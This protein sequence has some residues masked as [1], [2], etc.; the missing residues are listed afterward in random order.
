MVLYFVLDIVL[1]QN[2][3]SR[4]GPGGAL[5]D[6]GCASKSLRH[7]GIASTKNQAGHEDEVKFLR[8]Q[9]EQLY[10]ARVALQEKEN[11]LLRGLQGCEH[12]ATG[13]MRS[14]S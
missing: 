11:L 14:C 12:N 2:V 6:R 7:G 10:K 4:P 1:L 9:L 5:A 13:G 3:K 8:G